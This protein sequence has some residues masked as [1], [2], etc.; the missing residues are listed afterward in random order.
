MLALIGPHKSS[1]E[2]IGLVVKGL[3]E[4]GLEEIRLASIL[5]LVQMDYPGLYALV[6]IANRY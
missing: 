3:V 4:T 5:M 2:H 1:F 6:D